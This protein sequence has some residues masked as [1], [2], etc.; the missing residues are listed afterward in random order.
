LQF[1]VEVLGFFQKP[2][3]RRGDLRSHLASKVWLVRARISRNRRHAG[4]SLR[5]KP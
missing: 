4:Q 5:S 1:G 3:D 2:R